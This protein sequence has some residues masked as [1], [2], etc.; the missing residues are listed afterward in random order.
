M[1][2]VHTSPIAALGGRDA[3]GLNVY[4]RELAAHLEGL[5]RPVD[6][7]TRRTSPQQ[8][9]VSPMPGGGRLM[10][11]KAGPITP[12]PKD[13]LYAVLPEFLE[14]VLAFAQEEGGVYD[15]VHSHYWLSGWVGERL[16]QLWRVPHITRFHTLGEVKNRARFTER[17]SPR[18]IAV[19]R[20]VARTADRVICASAEEKSLL[21][22]YYGVDAPRI[23]VIPC[24]VDLD[25]FRPMDR[26]ACKQEL[27]LEGRKVLLYVGRLEALKGIDILLRACG[28]LSED[29]DF[30]LLIV[31]GDEHSQPRV[32][33]LRREAAALGI[34]DRVQFTG[35]IPHER[36]PVYYNAA[37]VCAVPSYYESFGLVAL[38]AMACA[39]PVVASR[40][41]G[42][43][44]TV[45]DGETGY[46]I[47][48]RCPE[49]FAERVET[50]LRNDDLRRRFG[51]AARR[52]A[53]AYRWDTVASDIAA[54]YDETRRLRTVATATRPSVLNLYHEL[55]AI[56]HR[57][58]PASA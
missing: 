53:S 44:S 56:E 46:L 10:T 30:H 32:R 13:D 34:Q 12:L 31:G 20:R 36:L 24:G 4:V 22:R 28:Q 43:S 29:V 6:V 54:L 58:W 8:P 39:T 45:R 23:A 50:L 18:R 40:V 55:A 1:L 57:H 35:S 37:D 33:S 7:F 49:P 2:S 17:E 26:A 19:E 52:A 9:S 3:G 5:G 16:Q 14:G 11:V 48:W 41:G 25:L 27:G 38:E 51:L 15:I 21:M 42:L 47:S